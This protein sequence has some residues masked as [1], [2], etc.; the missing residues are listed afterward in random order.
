MSKRRVLMVAGYLPGYEGITSY[1]ITLTKELLKNGWEVALVSDTATKDL[2]IPGRADL[3][4]EWIESL[5]IRHFYVSFPK[6]RR[7]SVQGLT[8][9]SFSIFQ[10]LKKLNSAI[11]EF[12]PDVIHVH[13]LSVSLFV[14]ILRIFHKVPCV[15]TC[16][17]QPGTVWVR[18]KL[19]VLFSQYVNIFFGDRCIAL[20]STLQDYFINTMRVPKD[21]VRL[22]YSG[23]DSQHF[24]PPSQDERLEARKHYGLTS[25]E[26]VICLIG[27]LQERKGHEILLQALANLRTNGLNVTTLFAGV[28]IWKSYI[29][30]KAVELGVADLIH[31]LGFTD[32]RQVLWASDIFVLPSWQEA[33]PL[34]IIEAM[35]CGV[36][37]VRTPTSGSADQIQQNVNGFIFPF[38]DHETLALHLKELL[39]S[40]TLKSQIADTALKLSQEKFTLN[41]MTQALINVY[42]EVTHDID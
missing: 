32:S 29:Q 30:E 36:V 38:G 1:L 33:F 6:F 5:G 26:Q 8:Q 13:S 10:S 2:N 24:R 4:T 25:E 19:G 15:V 28:G 39:E 9:D 12:Q 22:I 42:E 35:L 21:K 20:S 40:N 17:Q 14:Q 18:D 37:T 16:H 7:G 31:W 27:S 3:R 34:V 11:V 41:K 23:V